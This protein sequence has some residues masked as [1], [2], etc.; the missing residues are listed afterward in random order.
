[1]VTESFVK[2]STED[3]VRIITINRPPVNALGPTLM[4]QLKTAF[5]DFA[6][7]PKVKVAILTGAGSDVFV[8]GADL[9]DFGKI[10]NIFHA[11]RLT[12]MGQNLFSFIE[13]LNKPVICAINGVCLG[14]GNELAM[15]CHYRIA[16]ERAK[17][18]QPEINLGIIPGWGGTQ[19]LPR[20]VGPS[21]ATELIL[22]GDKISAQEAFR[23]GL[24][25]KVVP[26]T[27]LMKQAT[28]LARQIGQK[29]LISISRAMKAIRK[30]LN[31]KLNA[32]LCTEA[33]LF[34]G[35][36]ASQD[37]KEGI[38]AFL[39]KRQPQFQDR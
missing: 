38:R 11:L 21:K 23:L 1:M 15:S 7:D 22:T 26:E 37:C 2:I 34:L 5:Q 9:K 28:G 6:K 32:G 25:D 35:T 10:K 20:I 29:S 13:N 14:G 27:E 3:K 4:G 18:G 17:L 24:V 30:S 12:K 16:S 31:S 19:R 8:A 36:L 33:R 39:E